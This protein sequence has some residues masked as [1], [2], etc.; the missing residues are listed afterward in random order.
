MP[1]LVP[2]VKTVEEV[3][4]YFE[5]ISYVTWWDTFTPYMTLF[6]HDGL[7]REILEKAK[8]HIL[9]IKLYPEWMTTNSS[10]GVKDFDLEKLAHIFEAMSDLEIP[11]NIHGEA[12]GFV[13][14]RERLFIPTYEAL[15]KRFPRL[16]IIMEHITT[17]DAVELLDKYD[18]LY[19]T[20]TLQHLFIT[21]D[22]IAGWMLKPHLFCKPIAKLPHDRDALLEI[23][24]LGHKK[25]MFGSDSAPHPQE[26]KECSGCAAWVFT[27]PLILPTLVELFEKHNSLQNLQ[28]FVSDNAIYIYWITPPHK[29]VILIKEDMIVPE[30]YENVIP[31]KAGETITWSVKE[32]K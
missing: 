31:F 11:I 5:R 17:R 28:K 19:A 10:G 16:K 26:K 30:K 7:T 14:D 32:V 29:E 1:N 8:S 9:S 13:L 25:V 6:F 24:L 12:H 3:T 18:N 4:A 2:P 21:L 27:A 15:A 22:D 23:A 20:I